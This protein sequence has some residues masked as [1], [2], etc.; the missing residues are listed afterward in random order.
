MY[1][2]SK[3]PPLLMSIKI[4]IVALKVALVLKSGVPLKQENDSSTVL[5]RCVGNRLYI[6]PHL[7]GRRAF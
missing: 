2:S 7:D 6:V 3:K 5:G 4:G 1:R